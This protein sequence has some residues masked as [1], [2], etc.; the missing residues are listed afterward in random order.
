MDKNRKINNQRGKNIAGRRFG[1]LGNVG[2]NGCGAI[3]IYNADRILGIPASFDEIL[4]GF[5]GCKHM[6]RTV[7]FGLLGGSPFYVRKYYKSRGYTA[8]WKRKKDVSKDADAYIVV[9]FYAAGA[10]YQAGEYHSG[11]FHMN[12][13]EQS[14]IDIDEMNAVNGN[15]YTRVLE[16]C[17]TRV[18][19]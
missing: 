1:L 3:A 8:R 10:H 5:N 2:D 14:F 15:F 4:N 19:Q 18:L 9:Q 12:N 7:A 17:K 11:R 13:R 16:I 6:M